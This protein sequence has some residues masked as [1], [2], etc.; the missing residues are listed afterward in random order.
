MWSALLF[1]VG[2]TAAGLQL[3]RLVWRY[4]RLRRAMRGWPR[5][6]AE[7]L[8]DRTELSRGSR[9]IDVQL[10]YVHEGRMYE[11]W[12]RS[13]TRSAYGRGDRQAGRQVAALYPPGSTQQAFVNPATPAE[14]FLELPEPH[15]L[16]MMA[17]GGT[18]L[19]ALAV[20]V[21]P[22]FGVDPE[23]VTLGFM[24][25][26]ALV[27]AVV[28]VFAAV[29][30]W[31]RRRR[32]PRGTPGPQRMGGLLLLVAATSPWPGCAGRDAETALAQRVESLIAPLVAAH[33]LSGAIVLSREGQVVYERGMGLANV[34]AGLAFTPDTAAD[35]A[36]LA[37][38]FT[39]A[40]IWSLA[41]EGRIDLDAPVVRYVPEYPHAGTTVRHL[42]S[43]SNGLPPDYAFFD[44]H[45]TPETVKTTRGL[46]EI[47]SREAP[48]PGFEPGTRF[49]YSNVGFDAA[50]LVIEAASGQ[51]YE[52]FLRQRY[53]TPLGMT[54]TFARPARFADWP[55]VRTLGYRWRDGAWAIVDVFDMEAFLGASN[56]Y[57]TARD[58]ARWTNAHAMGTALPPAVEQ[59]GRERPVIDGQRSAINGLSWYCDDQDTRCYYSGMLNAFHSLAYWDRQRRESV[60]LVTNSSVPP[61]TVITLQRDL[62]A[63]LAGAGSADDGTRNTERGAGPA[64]S[65]RGS[66]D[67]ESP[68]DRVSP[69]EAAAL[70]PAQLAGTYQ[71]GG[72]DMVSIAAR[73]SGV[74]MRVNCG[75][76][77]A[78]FPVSRT[79]LYVPGTDDFVTFTEGPDPVVLHRRSMFRD[80]TL[81]RSAE[82]TQAACPPDLRAAGHPCGCSRR[83]ARRVPR[84]GIVN[85]CQPRRRALSRSATSSTCTA[86]PRLPH[87]RRRRAS[88]A[89]SRRGASDSR[90]PISTSPPSRP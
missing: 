75:L 9:R 25:V 82:A 36:S 37:K 17:G 7:V 3:W 32:P 53:F 84:A 29:A 27:L 43:H 30:L 16:A 8:G 76:E 79:V 10:R 74:T 50:A 33:E 26:V 4:L 66:P 48:R 81:T 60:V 38:T 57:F 24:L 65:G 5:V 67:Q 51:D 1:A 18:L 77:Y 20:A 55:G 11:V 6:A 58:L 2:V 56:L 59:A 15:M 47:V 63:A 28:A 40:A 69:S 45:F 39:A 35:G 90:V 46:L 34:A 73:A 85:R 31:P 19:I 14:A 12:S 54:A 44:P 89:N 78:V 62:V 88:R 83:L 70:D 49:E 64:G 22:V 41:V 42:I 86:S 23:I 80:E 71:S 13:P 68:T 21:P 52:A 87:R 61:W 72:G